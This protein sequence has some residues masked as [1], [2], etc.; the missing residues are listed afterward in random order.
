MQ[1]KHALHAFAVRDAADGESLIETAAL[2][3]DHYTGKDL[4]SFL[5]A[6][7]D[8][9]VDSHTVANRKGRDIAFLLLFLNGIDDLV[10]KLLASARGCG[11][12]LSFEGGAFA[13]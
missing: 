7:H 6:F 8:S 1:R 13:T 3:T 5:I 4:D 2:A 11:R 12:T 10:H 9:R